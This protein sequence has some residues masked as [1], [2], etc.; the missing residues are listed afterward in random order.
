MQF[1]LRYTKGRGSSTDCLISY[2]KSKHRIPESEN[3]KTIPAQ[4]EIRSQ[5]VIKEIWVFMMLQRRGQK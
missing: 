2:F 1:V 5:I 4:E 3:H